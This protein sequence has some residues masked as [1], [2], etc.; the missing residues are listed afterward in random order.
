MTAA[1]HG[2]RRFGRAE[3]AHLLGLRRI[4]G[5]RAA[6]GFRR[7]TLARA[8]DKTGK[9][10]ERRIAGCF[11]LLDFIPVESIAIAGDERAHHRMIRLMRLQEAYSAPFFAAGAADHLMQE[12][13]RALGGARVAIAET[14]IGI[15]D[16]D[17]IEL[18]EMMA[19]GDELRTDNKIEAALRDVLK[20]AAKSLDRIHEIARQ[21][22]NAR[23]GK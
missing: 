6:I 12:L 2:D 5:K 11:A 20:L 13:E 23:L 17:E 22:E 4:R 3:H 19:L 10:S 1:H 7:V 8:H 9:A 15:D 16:T 14:E 18:G 21:D